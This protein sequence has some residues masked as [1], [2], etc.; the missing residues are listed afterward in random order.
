MQ[1]QKHAPHVYIRRWIV[2]ALAYVRTATLGVQQEG[3]SLL[4]SEQQNVNLNRYCCQ[5]KRRER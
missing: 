4:Y 5:R 2:G 3:I 1:I